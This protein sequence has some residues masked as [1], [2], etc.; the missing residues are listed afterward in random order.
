MAK[1]KLVRK[2][3]RIESGTFDIGKT[4]GLTTIHKLIIRKKRNVENTYTV[5]VEASHPI[6][7]KIDFKFTYNSS[8]FTSHEWDNAVGG[9][10]CMGTA[11]KGEIKDIV[12]AG[13]ADESYAYQIS[14]KCGAW[15]HA[16]TNPENGE[17]LLWHY[18]YYGE[19]SPRSKWRLPLKCYEDSLWKQHKCKICSGSKCEFMM[20]K[21]TIC[22]KK[23]KNLCPVCNTG[24]CTI[25]S[26]CMNGHYVLTDEGMFEGKCNRCNAKIPIGSKECFACGNKEFKNF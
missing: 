5:N 9:R 25:H 3:E 10:M 21:C 12:I 20:H 26:K 11:P 6:F 22:G 19:F 17:Y 8:K 1:T 14:L 18:K 16:E 2:S 15:I 24:V 4:V 7:N 23:T 13:V